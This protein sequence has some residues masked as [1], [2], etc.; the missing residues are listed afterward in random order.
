[1]FVVNKDH[2]TLGNDGR[3]L[4]AFA[5]DLA[6]APG[7]WPLHIGVVDAAQTGFLFARADRI[8]TDGGEFG[9]YNYR[10]PSGYTLVV[11]ND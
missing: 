11:F 3:S 6:L 1:M 4:V 10:T 7:Q 8:T 9:G 5:S 2:V